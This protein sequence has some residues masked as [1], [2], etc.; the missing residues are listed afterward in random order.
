MSAEKRLTVWK[1][2]DSDDASSNNIENIKDVK[3]KMMKIIDIAKSGNGL[4]NLR[5][6]LEILT[7]YRYLSVTV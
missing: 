1:S 7:Y 2:P 5:T 3:A 6:K 4:E